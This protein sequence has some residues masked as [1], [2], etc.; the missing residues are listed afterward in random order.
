MICN[1]L[2]VITLFYPLE[3]PMPGEYPPLPVFF[4]V[5]GPCIP[6]R[7]YM[8]PALGRCPE[9]RSLAVEGHYFVVRSARQSGKTTLLQSLV[10]EI[11]EQRRF[12]ALFCSLETLQGIEDLE[13]GMQGVL[14]AVIQALRWSG[15]EPLRNALDTF[16]APGP[17]VVV[18]Q[19]LM[20]LC[21]ALDKPLILFFDET[22]C[23]AGQ[24]LLS[25]LR[26]LRNGYINRAAI[27]FPWSV[28]LTGMR[29]IRDFKAQ[30]RQPGETPGS[31]SPFNIIT[32]TLTLHDFTQEQTAELY[33]Q[34]TA[35]TGQIFEPDAAARAYY[36]TEGQPRLVN[37]LARQVVEKDLAR[38]YSKAVSASCIDSAAETLLQ[39]RDTHI[40]SLMEH[41]KEPRVRKVIEPVLCGGYYEVDPLADDT[42]FCL[43]IGLLKFDKH[44]GLRPSN[45]MYRDIMVRVLNFGTQFSL[46]S[47]LEHRWMDGKTLDMTALL[48]EFQRFWRENSEFWIERYDYKEAAPHLILQA[49]LQR[50]TNGGAQIEREYALGLGRVD[51]CVKYAG[52]AY[53]VE[54]KLARAGAREQGA[55]QLQRYMA[56]CGARD[57]W[58][59][60]FDRDPVKAWVDDLSWETDALPDGGTLHIVRC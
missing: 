8:I 56:R 36:W 58:L 12:Y 55:A 17:T 21:A 59:V 57:G 32:D 43:D 6:G 3:S 15:A 54:I 44:C 30:V 19:A 20:S 51:V 52:N 29:D 27:P 25:F 50:V 14:D 38:D 2:D 28:A 33:A 22:D 1:S 42:Q 11:N 7:H 9:A 13:E 53:P 34:H 10:R 49:F 60:I 48:K 47:N 26:Q 46:P 41:L 4:N 16:A 37:A 31:V 18:A 24:T 40:D 23:L 39:R 45:P 5:A 35:A